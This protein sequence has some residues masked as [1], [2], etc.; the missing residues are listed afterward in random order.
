LIINDRRKNCLYFS[1]E[2]IETK[3]NPNYLIKIIEFYLNTV[4]LRKPHQ[5]KEKIYFFLDEIQNIPQW[6]EVVKFY[7]DQ[8]DNFKFIICGSNSLFIKKKSKESLGGRIIEIQVSPLSFKEYLELIRPDFE[9]LPHERIWILS[10]MEILNAHFE[11]YLRW[12]QFPEVIQ[13]KLDRN[14]TKIYI[15]SIE[16]KITQQDLPKIFPIEYPEVFSAILNQIKSLPGQ[17]IEYQNIAKDVGLDKRTLAKYFDYLEKGFL[18]SFCYNFGKKP[19]KAPRIAK[20]VYLGSSNFALDASL[21]TLVE[22]YVFNYLQKQFF[23]VYFHKDKEI[24]FVAIDKKRN[25]FLFEVKFQNEIQDKDTKNMEDF[26]ERQPNTKSFLVT[27]K[28]LVLRGKIKQIP[29]SLVEFIYK[30]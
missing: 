19:I 18:I 20:K 22:N 23:K 17:R 5:I 12:G 3:R 25:N 30:V 28:H 13:Q 1:F 15:E 14:Q 16:E 8:N 24:D 26:M 29:A 2:K 4:L 9:I 27:K 11:K 21:S 6:Q 7:Y 10:N